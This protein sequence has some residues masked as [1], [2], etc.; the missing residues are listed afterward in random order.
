MVAAVLT[1]CGSAQATPQVSAAAK[2]SPSATAAAVTATLPVIP[3][4]PP[5]PPL[6]GF[7]VSGSGPPSLYSATGMRTFTFPTN[8]PY[9]VISPLGTRLLVEHQVTSGM[10]LQVDALDAM[11]STGAISKLE[12]ITDSS[13]FI[14][15]IGSPDGTKWA[16]MLKG[17]VNGCGGNP[18]PPTDTFVYISSTPGQ[19]TLLAKLPPLKPNGLGWT[20]YQWTDAGIVLDE[21]GRPGCYE[22]P[23]INEDATDLLNPATG[24]VTALTPKLGTG[25]CILQDIANDGTVACIP[26]AVA[27]QEH[28]PTASATVLRIVLPTGTQKNITA[29]QFLQGCGTSSPVLF[30]D[31]EITGAADFVSLTRLCAAP[32]SDTSSLLDTWIIDVATLNDVKV[33]VTGLDATGWFPGTSTLIATGNLENYGDGPY[34]AGTYAVAADGS[35]T[36]LTTADLG[37][38]SFAHF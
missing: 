5:V 32:H 29:A 30:G 19:A 22:G 24:T 26:S 1:A 6:L 33:S 34:S 7:D 36:E 10:Y 13:D 17:P 23:R 37:T 21:G 14:D 25:D 12:T 28:A 27:V 35:A 20:F 11:T 8:S 16:W 4:A 15:A 38:V 3:P 31:V 2:A 18:P 9:Q